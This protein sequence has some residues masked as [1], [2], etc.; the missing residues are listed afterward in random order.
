[1]MYKIHEDKEGATI[2]EGDFVS[3]NAIQKTEEDSVIYNSYDYDRPA[4]LLREKSAFQG[5]LFTAIGMLSEGDSATFKINIDSMT[6]KMGM[7]RPANIKGQYMVYTIKVNKVIPKGKSTEQAFQSQIDGFLKAEQD[8]AKNSEAGR[9]KDYIK[10]ENLKPTV[11]AS[12]LNYVITKKGNGPVARA[13][14]T[15]EV[16]YTGKFLSGKV[17]D[18][19]LEEVAKKE[20]TYMQ[21]RPYQPIK[22]PVGV[23]S[24]IIQ[25]WEEA[26][27]LLPEGTEAT[28]ILPS[29]LAY[30]EQGS[31]QMIPP[32]APLVFDVQIVDVIP[33]K[34][35]PAPAA[36]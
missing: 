27:L 11:T 33:A 2:Q 7:P 32:Y 24:G 9:M 14:D 3:L 4:L 23:G 8:K 18:T 12:G 35:T 17:F 10:K 36:K 20:K 6:T 29:R 16:N 28:L 25:G 21:G 1:M 19:S 13:G 31:P 5:D 22:V 30:G 15:V 26:L 34:A